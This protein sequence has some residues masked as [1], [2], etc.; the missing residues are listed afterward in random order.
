MTPLKLRTVVC[1]AFMFGVPATLVA[2]QPA[3]LAPMPIVIAADDHR[4][5][6]DGISR[7]AETIARDAAITASVK[8]KLL[9]DPDVAGMKIDVDT[10]NK[11]VMLSGKV[12]SQT[13]AERA[14]ALTKGADGVVSVT[15]HLTVA[16]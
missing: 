1:A 6:N 12:A 4:G 13:Q 11:V 7:S 15:N 16:Q 14:V 8:T 5:E 2:G 10:F 3:T 9:A